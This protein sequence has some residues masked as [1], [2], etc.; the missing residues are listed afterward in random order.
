MIGLIQRVSNAKVEVEGEVIG[1]IDHGLL[2]LLGI[3]RGDGAREADRLLERVLTYR[4]FDDAEGKMNRSL[5]DTNGSLLVVSQFTLAADT[6]KGT[7]PGFST[8][9]SP[10]DGAH[11][12][13]HLV[14]EARR[15]VGTV[16]TGQFAPSEP[17][18]SASRRNSASH[19]P[20]PQR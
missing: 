17:A 14:E 3:E 8:A 2:M 9:A 6:H 20:S 10:Q 11:W 15:K 7:R 5:I 13:H 12:Y 1:Q 19:R 4:V 18:S 16:A